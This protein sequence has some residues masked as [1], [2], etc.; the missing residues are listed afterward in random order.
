MPMVGGR[1]VVK[2][3]NMQ[4]SKRNTRTLTYKGIFLISH[5]IRLKQITS[6]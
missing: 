5:I 3:K 6:H 4:E 1:R 2:D